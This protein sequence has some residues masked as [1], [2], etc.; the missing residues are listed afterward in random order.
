VSADACKCCQC[1]GKRLPTLTKQPCRNQTSVAA[2]LRFCLVLKCRARRR[3]EISDLRPQ[4]LFFHV[5]LTPSRSL[6]TDQKPQTGRN[7]PIKRTSDARNI[8]RDDVRECGQARHTHV[9]L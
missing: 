6:R 3:L 8:C 1:G 9:H 4:A 2:A 5:L 7:N